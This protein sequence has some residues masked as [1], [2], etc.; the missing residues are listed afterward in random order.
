MPADAIGDSFDPARIL[1]TL[2]AHSVDFLLVGGFAAEAH[3]ALRQTYDLDLVPQPSQDNYERL[4]AALRELNARLRV[5]GMTDEEARQLPV[6][7]DGRTLRSFGNSTWATDAGAVDVLTE[8]PDRDG[9]RRSYQE[10]AIRRVAQE[11]GGVIVQLAAL[12]DIVTSKE[13]ADRPKDHDAL[14][15]LRQL[16]SRPTDPDIGLDL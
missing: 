8:L 2:A 5:G 10:L 4:A 12:D 16:Q 1:A 13:F 15:E 3:G 14:P 7:V 9:R 11:I 6:Q